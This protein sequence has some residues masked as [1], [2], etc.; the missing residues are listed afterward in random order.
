MYKDVSHEVTLQVH[1]GRQCSP[2]NNIYDSLVLAACLG[3][4]FQNSSLKNVAIANSHTK[5]PSQSLKY[6]IYN[7]LSNDLTFIIS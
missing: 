7:I 5:I 1:N 3:L 6:M 4:C 2:K